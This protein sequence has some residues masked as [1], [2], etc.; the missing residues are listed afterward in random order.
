MATSKRSNTLWEASKSTSGAHI[1]RGVDILDRRY[2]LADPSE[3][4]NVSGLCEVAFW[5]K[6]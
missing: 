5:A 6:N 4:R 1:S 2:S 3:S